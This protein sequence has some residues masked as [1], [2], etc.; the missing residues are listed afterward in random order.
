MLRPSSILLFGSSITVHTQHSRYACCPHLVLV[1][2][3]TNLGTVCYIHAPVH[4]TACTYVSVSAAILLGNRLMFTW[5]AIGTCPPNITYTGSARGIVGPGRSISLIYFI[6]LLVKL[7]LV[8][9][10]TVPILLRSS[11]FLQLFLPKPLSSPLLGCTRSHCK[12]T[13]MGSLWRV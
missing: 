9:L 2:Q 7:D 5:M 4:C 13:A 8:R 3:A 12:V 11:F 6:D 10:S 1:D